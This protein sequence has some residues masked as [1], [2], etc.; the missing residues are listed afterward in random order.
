[1][2]NLEELWGSFAQYI[3]SLAEIL[4]RQICNL[5][6]WRALGKG[7]LCPPPPGLH[8][9]YVCALLPACRA[10]G[11]YST[12]SLRQHDSLWGADWVH[13]NKRILQDFCICYFSVLFINLFFSLRHSQ[14]SGTASLLP[15]PGGCSGDVSQV[16][17]GSSSSS[18]PTGGKDVTGSS[19]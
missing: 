12:Q 8:C 6:A 19:S 16:Q 10:A 5:Q 1:M 17:E 15:P 2:R 3:C 13:E 9:R 14:I 18:V 7:V 4:F 11:G